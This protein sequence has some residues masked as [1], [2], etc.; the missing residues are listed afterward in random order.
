MISVEGR[1][2][3]GH[4]LAIHHAGDRTNNGGTGD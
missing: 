3:E 4:N 2:K 1:E